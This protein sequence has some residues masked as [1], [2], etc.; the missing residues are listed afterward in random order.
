MLNRRG[1]SGMI[2]RVI[3][4]FSIMGNVH[5]TVL[6]VDKM[7]QSFPD[8]FI[9]LV[10]ISAGSGQVVSYIGREGNGVMVNAAA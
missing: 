8:N 4:H 7:R 5:D 2:L 3:P 9:G 6:M 1:H 10:G